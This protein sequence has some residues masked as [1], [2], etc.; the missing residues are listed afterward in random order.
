MP[1]QPVASHGTSSVARVSAPSLARA[2]A[3]YRAELQAA[4]VIDFDISG[5][6]AVG[7]PVWA[8]WWA[9]PK[10]GGW[11]GGGI[12]YGASSDQAVV[13]ALGETVERAIG[14]RGLR[15]MSK[16]LQHGSERDLVASL[17]RG[18][19]VDPRSLGLP[20][21][22]DY[23]D[24]RP[25]Q[26]VPTLR[27]GDD[28]TVWVPVEFVASGVSDVPPPVGGQWLIHPVT[29]GLGA[30][31]SRDQAVAHAIG[32][33]LQ[34][35]GNGVCFRALDRGVVLDITR[36]RDAVTVAALRALRA[37]GVRATVKLASTEQGVINVYV[38]G[39]APGDDVIIATACGEA[40]HPDADTAIRKAVLEFAA[41]RVRKAFMHGP[42]SIVRDIAPANYFEAV[43]TGIDPA[44]EE[45]RV[46]AAMLRWVDMPEERWRPLV[47]A[48]VFARSTTVDYDE[49]PKPGPGAI[50]D[51]LQAMRHSLAAEGFDVLVADF[52]GV[53][54]AHVV[55]VI[56]PGMEVETVAY[57]RLGERNARRL[58][59]MGRD[60]LIR[61]G[62]GP[63]GWSS[64]ALTEQAT[65][66]LGG[67][68][69][70]DRRRL[71]EVCGDLLPLYREPGRHAL[72]LALQ[73]RG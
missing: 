4:A 25:L 51:P 10:A 49:L 52:V 16:E 12:G 21:G 11:R 23:D 41:A 58:L 2:A 46:L 48:T 20:A 57:G 40:A 61:I 8:T 62:E 47:A 14:V 27:L 9:D 33:I 53:A 64:V 5:L 50:A 17:G 35:D 56:I 24:R 36:C 26:W 42:L 71:S 70:L 3:T 73:R 7:L 19:V 6:G 66:R 29:N 72:Q 69:W 32:E 65:Q 43:L 34:R 18:H 38:V 22:T 55:K 67:P 59:D 44:A 54:G 13:G 37:A 15:A 30:G 63:P 28:A 31:L 39:E 1:R 45:P 60:D 68:A